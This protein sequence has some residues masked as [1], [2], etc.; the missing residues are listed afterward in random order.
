MY[1]STNNKNECLK[2]RKNFPNLKPYISSLSSYSSY[3]K[4]YVKIY[5]YGNNFL[6]NGFTNINFGNIK[7]IPVRYINTN[8]LYVELY[9]FLFPGVY[10]LVVVNTLPIY[11]KN[12][13]A[14]SLGDTYLQS[15]I[16]N[17]TVTN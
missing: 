8:T 15:N 4:N 3:F 10:D 7:N 6:P 16:V 14:N 1:L 17:Y 11:A 12:T 13:T 5:I 2:Y 9:N